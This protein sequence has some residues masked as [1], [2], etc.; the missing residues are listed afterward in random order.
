M[1]GAL[2]GVVVALLM[3]KQRESDVEKAQT[4][5]RRKKARHVGGK[6]TSNLGPS[7]A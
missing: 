6:Q 1:G 5:R 4:K 3:P 2:A 7:G